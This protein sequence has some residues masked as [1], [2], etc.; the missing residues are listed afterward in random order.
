MDVWLFS[1]R[2]LP[3]L[4]LHILLT[5]GVFAETTMA[6]QSQANLP[7]PVSDHHPYLCSIA[8]DRSSKR[9]CDRHV[10]HLP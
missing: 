4:P 2:R 3:N 7:S 6:T 9:G 8:V 5:A 1:R 10:R